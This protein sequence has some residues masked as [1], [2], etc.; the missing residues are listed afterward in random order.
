MSLK[1][2]VKKSVTAWSPFR[3]LISHIS[4]NMP[5]VFVY[6]RFAPAEVPVPSHR[7]NADNFAWQLER[8]QQYGRI[9]PLSECLEYYSEHHEW[10]LGVVV[11]TVD[12][13]YRDFYHYAFP[14]LQKRGIPATL[15]PAV[16]FIERKIWLWPD[17]LDAALS[18][19]E[20]GAV[21]VKIKEISEPLKLTFTNQTERSQ[22]WKTLSD[23]C[24]SSADSIRQKLI[25]EVEEQLAVDLPR[26]P[27]E[28]YEAC[29]WDE[30]REMR[31]GGI[32]IGSHT[33]N[34][35][36]LS[37]ID[38]TELFDEIHTSKVEIEKQIN[39]P[40]KT[41]CYPNSALGD[42]NDRVVEE[43]RQAGYVG[44]VFG[45][46][47]CHWEPYKIPR[48][49]VSNDRNDFLSKLA[50]LELLGRKARKIIGTNPL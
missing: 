38:E 33:M 18:A 3:R 48:M 49:G 13:G 5:R 39:D 23:L 29:T 36:I 30:I 19:H 44:A 41:F 2:F 6:H 16:N 42:I 47:L 43:V 25:A 28:A 26:V 50:G 7:I 32:E 11:I 21:R 37:K 46:D 4:G 24:I 20:K 31:D 8:M 15:F 34:H 9:V 35:P 17:R 14:E 27:P 45:T 10:P 12:D 22:V 1:R 40:V